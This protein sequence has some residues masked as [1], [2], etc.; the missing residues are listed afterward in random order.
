[1]IRR[2]GVVARGGSAPLRLDRLA[3]AGVILGA[4][5]AAFASP[6]T[7]RSYFG[8]GSTLITFEDQGNGNP[9]VSPDLDPLIQGETLTLPASEYASLGVTFDRDLMWVNDGNT[10]FDAAVTLSEMAGQG[11]S[12]ILSIPSDSIDAFDIL[13][14]TPVNAFGFFVAHNTTEVQRSGV[15]FTAY[16]E[17]DNV[18][19]FQAFGGAFVDNTLQNANTSVAYGFMGIARDSGQNPITRVTVNKGWAILDD[20]VFTPVPTPG[21]MGLFGAAGL[22]AARRRRRIA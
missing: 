1:M 12:P 14:S 16:D 2:L 6:I 17:F 11:G 8:P 15:T 10:L 7:D 13:F 4:S 9:V 19:D 5:G 3:A 18:V 20:L 21:S 22:I